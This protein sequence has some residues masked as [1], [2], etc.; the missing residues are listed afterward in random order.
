MLDTSELDE[1]L[2]WMRANRILKAK[3]GDLELVAELPQEEPPGDSGLDN[4]MTHRR[5]ESES[6]YLDTDLWN[7]EPPEAIRAAVPK[8]S[9]DDDGTGH[10][11]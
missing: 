2:S 10:A 6:M 11:R 1:L 7:G 4:P 8:A 3:L 5:G 9:K